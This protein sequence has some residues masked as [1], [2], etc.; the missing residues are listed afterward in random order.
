MDKISQIA[1]ENS[2]EKGIRIAKIISQSGLCSRREAEAMILEAEDF[3]V[4]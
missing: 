4:P 2:N 1:D 3:P